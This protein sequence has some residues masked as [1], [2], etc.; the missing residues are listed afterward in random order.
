MG[1]LTNKY[2][3]S[4]LELVNKKN[5]QVI[6]KEKDYISSHHKLS[7]LCQDNHEF[8]I[9]LNNLKKDRWCPQCSTRKMERYTK[10]LVR[11]EE[12]TV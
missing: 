9:C 11:S 7:V 10:Q 2:F 12:H 6:S 5:G 4:F 1:Q 8:E 3:I